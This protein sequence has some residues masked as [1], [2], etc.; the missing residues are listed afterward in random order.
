[1]SSK[2]TDRRLVAAAALWGLLAAARAASAAAPVETILG[3]WRGTSTCV[4]SAEFPSCHDEI[5]VYEF[6]RAAAGGD[7]VTLAAYKIVG[8]EKLLMGE[9]DFD[10]DARQAAWT[11]E[12]RSAQ[13]HGLWTFFVKGDAITGTLVDLPSR[14]VV[15]N[16]AVR[17][18]AAPAK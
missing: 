8:G 1:M 15:R 11:S 13:Y 12:F 14:H 5:V 10:Y 18:E 17:R 16:V 7:R 4:K 3:E 2:W 6:R 9:M